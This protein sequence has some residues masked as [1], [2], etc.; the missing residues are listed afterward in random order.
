MSPGRRRMRRRSAA[1]M[2]MLGSS[3]ATGVQPASWPQVETLEDRTLLVASLSIN[4]PAVTEGDA[5]STNLHFTVT[6]GGDDTL[7]GSIGD[8]AIFGGRN[9]PVHSPRALQLGLERGV[10]LLAHQGSRVRQSRG[11]L[12]P[13]VFHV[14]K[15]YFF[16]FDFFVVIHRASVGI[17]QLRC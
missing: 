14:V 10:S 6:R 4:D 7:Y 1:R 17:K 13:F 15:I 8:D 3:A 16:V 2:G 5:G 12:E 11:Y 9:A